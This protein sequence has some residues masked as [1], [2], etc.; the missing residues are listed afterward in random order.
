MSSSVLWAIDVGAPRVTT[1]LHTCAKKIIDVN[2]ILVQKTPYSLL[3]R[4][5]S[6]NVE[7]TVHSFQVGFLT[8]EDIYYSCVVDCVPGTL[9]FALNNIFC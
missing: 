4:V 2:T 9:T 7:C 3:H 6:C 5:K 1:Y 8:K